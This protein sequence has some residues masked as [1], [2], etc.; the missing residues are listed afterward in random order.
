[1]VCQAT[2]HWPPFTSSF[3]SQKKALKLSPLPPAASIC[4]S[5]SD[6]KTAAPHTKKKESLIIFETKKHT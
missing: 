4:Y 5:P 3:P 1:M 2:R 6:R